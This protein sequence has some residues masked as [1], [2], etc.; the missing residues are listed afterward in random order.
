MNGKRA[1]ALRKVAL[2]TACEMLPADP[3]EHAIPNVRYVTQQH[4]RNGFVIGQSHRL[5]PCIR[6]VEKETKRAFTNLTR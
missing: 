5:G 4:S 3:I 2:D 1:K 6:K